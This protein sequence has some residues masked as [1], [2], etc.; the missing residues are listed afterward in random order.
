MVTYS[1][2]CLIPGL[3][4]ICRYLSYAIPGRSLVN[5]CAAHPGGGF[6]TIG[7]CIF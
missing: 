7:A 2:G 5:A 6:L 1:E 4:V 3:R